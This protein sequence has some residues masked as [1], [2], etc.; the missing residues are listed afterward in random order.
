LR[1]KIAPGW[2]PYPIG[3]TKQRQGGSYSVGITKQHQVVLL[4]IKALQGG[5]VILYYVKSPWLRILRRKMAPGIRLAQ[6]IEV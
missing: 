4:Y 2:L 1:R 5:A 6:I 3:I